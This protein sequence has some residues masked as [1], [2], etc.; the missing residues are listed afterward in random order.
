M[1]RYLPQLGGLPFCNLHLE[2]APHIGL[3]PVCSLL[4]SLQLAKLFVRASALCLD[5][6]IC[7]MDVIGNSIFLSHP[8]F[9][10]PG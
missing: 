9:V 3:L 10:Y 1:C 6:S 8:L 5:L 7:L 2:Y 4:G